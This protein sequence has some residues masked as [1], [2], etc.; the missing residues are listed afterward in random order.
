MIQLA[1]PSKKLITLLCFALTSTLLSLTPSSF[2][3][4][5]QS[6]IAPHVGAIYINETRQSSAGT[7]A[8]TKGY[9][10]T[11]RTDFMSIPDHVSINLTAGIGANYLDMG[12]QFRLF[13]YATLR[14]L[15]STGVIYGIGAGFNYSKGYSPDVVAD[16]IPFVDLLATA[17]L[18]FQ[19]D[20]QN[21]WGMFFET[22]Y[23]GVIQ[24]S[25]IKKGSTIEDLASTH[26][27]IFAVGIPFE[28][29]ERSF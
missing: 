4:T 13:D 21:A 11:F 28:F 12:A 10:Y 6:V 3:D 5:L 27:F 8:Q 2:A 20:S 9:R 16:R 19:F 1:I 23:E 22:A 15:G 14:D 18:R 29:G 25:F 7:E 24:R 17:F 26:R